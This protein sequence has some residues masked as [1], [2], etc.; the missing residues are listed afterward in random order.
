MLLSI[1]Y[2]YHTYGTTDFLTL[3]TLLET[4]AFDVDV[5]KLIFLAFFASFAVKIPSFP[6]HI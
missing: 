2:I 4:K 3:L 5:Q 1:F 6:F